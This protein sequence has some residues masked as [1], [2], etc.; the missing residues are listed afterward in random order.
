MSQLPRELALRIA[1]AARVLPDVDVPRL[2]EILH[3][4]VG[5]PLDDE[6][7]KS[8]VLNCLDSYYMLEARSKKIIKSSNY[9]PEDIEL[10]NALSEKSTSSIASKLTK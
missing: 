10:K 8:A 2:I 1:L 7:L 5:V 6:K 4:K 9:Q 3:E